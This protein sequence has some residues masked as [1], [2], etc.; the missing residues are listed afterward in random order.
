[1]RRW[2]STLWLELLVRLIY[3]TLPG[4]ARRAL[5]GPAIRRDGQTL[6]PDLQLLLRL[7]G[8]TSAGRSG[9]T[10][11]QRRMH[12]D[13]ATALLSGRRLAGV[14]VRSLRI[15]A[16]HGR[17]PARLYSPDGLA[18]G[19]PLLVFHHGGG[20][21]T[22]SLDSHEAVCR[23]LAV[24]AGVRVLAIEYRLAPEHP[25]P[26]GVEDAVA[27]FRYARDAAGELG[28]DP[29]A[30]ALGGDS[31]G[32]NLAAVVAHLAARSG[33][34][35]PAFLLLFYPACDA[36]HR[37]PSRA[38]FG[39][40]FLLTE[41]DIDWFLDHYLPARDERG[42]PRASI[43]LAEDL[44][45]MP[46]TYLVTAGFDPLRDEGEEF[47]A[48]LADAGVPVA[49]RRQPDLVHGFVN[50]LGVGFRCREAVAEAA[51]A[52]RIGVALAATESSRR[53]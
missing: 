34:P 47:A 1:M 44:S 9:S 42:D 13:V 36:V 11:A 41:A 6:D 45:G 21:V 31:A 37:T 51:G 22:G 17:I 4:V 16:E 28:A 43:L 39:S 53:S 15:P 30:V 29:A 40:G 35:V 5:A 24:H 20:W 18:P 50:M 27:A 25:F 48:R 2:R 52:L 23:Y 33:E 49:L 19:S 10:P 26:A 46:P 38:L 8:L 3:R 14:S 32:A 7:E 12:L